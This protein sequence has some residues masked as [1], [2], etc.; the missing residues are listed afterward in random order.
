MQTERVLSSASVPWVPGRHTME[1]VRSTRM[2]P[3]E[4][5]TAGFVLVRDADERLLLTHVNLP[6]RGW[7]APGGHLD[8]GEDVLTAAVREVAEETGFALSTTDL[9]LIGW[10]RFTLLDEAPVDYEYPAP[11]SYAVWFSARTG[12]AAPPLAPDERSEC[13]PAGWFTRDEAMRRCATADWLPFY[14]DIT[15]S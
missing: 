2:P 8:A 3:A 9:S 13:G 15:G 1:N 5:I 7:D 12:L 6:G 14:R 4:Q 11:V 10:Q